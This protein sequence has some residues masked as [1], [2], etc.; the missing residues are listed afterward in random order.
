MCSFSGYAYFSKIG[1]NDIEKT[2]SKEKIDLIFTDLDGNPKVKGNLGV[3]DLEIVRKETNTIWL[4]EKPIFGGVNMYTIFLDKNIAIWSKQYDMI[5][6]TPTG[7]MSMG[8]C[9]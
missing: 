7:L 6:L 4:I 3:M 8:K 1:H 5:N 9:K 2:F